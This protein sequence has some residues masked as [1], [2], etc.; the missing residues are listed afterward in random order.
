[1]N[2]MYFLKKILYLIFYNIL[3][4]YLIIPPSVYPFSLTSSAPSL[5]PSTDFPP[6]ESGGV[7]L[8]YSKDIGVIDGGSG[9]LP[10]EEIG[11]EEI[12]VIE[13]DNIILSTLEPFN[14]DTMPTLWQDALLP[15]QDF[16]WRSLI[17]GL[18]G[19]NDPLLS[20]FE[21]KPWY[22]NAGR[23]NVFDKSVLNYVLYQAALR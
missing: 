12:G 19:T 18:Q 5:L 21:G 11:G 1:M 22:D 3:I 23:W 6:V 8:P 14:I 15:T 7:F 13:G 10:M 4:L 17:V 9:V 2:K 16:I 20:Q